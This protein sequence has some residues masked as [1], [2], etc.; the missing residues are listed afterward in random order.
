MFKCL[1]DQIGTVN[2]FSFTPGFLKFTERVSLSRSMTIYKICRYGYTILKLLDP[3]LHVEVVTI[4]LWTLFHSY[5]LT[6]FCLSQGRKYLE[7]Q[8][9]P[10]CLFFY[11]LAF[12][13]TITTWSL[14]VL[15]Y[16]TVPPY[17]ILP[18]LPDR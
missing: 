13:H 7:Y 18:R 8:I 3:T 5:R 14:H 10:L 17:L 16:S 11:P 9:G 6:L 15:Q 12:H 2:C 4:N 1:L